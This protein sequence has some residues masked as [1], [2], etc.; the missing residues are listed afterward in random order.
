[1]SAMAL[2]LP[3]CAAPPALHVLFGL[4]KPP[5]IIEGERRGLEYELIDMIVS[6][7]GYRLE[8]TFVPPA[9]LISLVRIGEF[10][11]AA[12][13]RETSGLPGY[14]SSPYI[15]YQ[16]V[17]IALAKRGVALHSIDDLSAYRV[18]AFQNAHLVLGE[19]FRHMTE[20]NA[21]YQEA[22]PQWIENNLLFSGH[23][24]VAIADWKIFRYFN[25]IVAGHVNTQQPVS[26]FAIFPPTDYQMVFRDAHLRDVFD[27][28]LEHAKRDGRYE[29]IMVRY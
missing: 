23:V 26:L 17:A 19:T 2:A 16:N 29:K 3:A 9:R 5:Y 13:V 4:N 8:P 18:V 21:S 10:D 15:Q 1:M 24:D 20:H 11:A 7:M 25:G 12:T 22:S 28:A 6:D 14:Y 27:K